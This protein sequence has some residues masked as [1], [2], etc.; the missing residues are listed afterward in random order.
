MVRTRRHC[1]QCCKQP[2]LISKVTQ[3]KSAYQALL[4]SALYFHGSKSMLTA[5]PAEQRGKE[6][7]QRIKEMSSDANIASA[8]LELENP[9][10]VSAFAAW[11]EKEMP[12]VNLLINNA[13][14]KSSRIIVEV[15][16]CE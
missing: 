4:S 2:G 14:E 7:V 10:S 6:A 13:G 8:Q 11:V 9:E 16:A 3:H 12:H 1:G 15:C 5:A